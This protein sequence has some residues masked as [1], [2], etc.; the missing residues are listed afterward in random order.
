MNNEI[1]QAG[2]I[3]MANG[4]HAPKVLLIVSRK[5]PRV[6]IFPKGHIE[7]GESALAAAERELVEEA[8]V[9]GK[10][11]SEVGTIT[12]QFSEKRYRVTYYLF[13]FAAVVSTGEDGRD[14]QWFSLEDAT[15]L[16][17][18]EGLKSMLRTALD[19]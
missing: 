18:F 7:P 4:T 5:K 17:P 10:L 13:E 12:Y 6:R 11:V 15:N 3:V 8:G 1:A 9:T 2:A 14:P 16:L 19:L